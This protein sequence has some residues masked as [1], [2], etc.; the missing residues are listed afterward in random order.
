MKAAIYCRVSTEDQMQI[1]PIKQFSLILLSYY[2]NYSHKRIILMMSK[3]IGGINKEVK[4]VTAR[5]ACI[6]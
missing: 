4:I 2:L 6:S 1:V 5:L 3:I